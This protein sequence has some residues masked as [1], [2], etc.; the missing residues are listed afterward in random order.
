M[1]VRFPRKYVVPPPAPLHTRY[2]TLCSASYG[3]QSARFSNHSMT[4]FDWDLFLHYRANECTATERERFER[5]LAADPDRRR[6]ADATIIAAERMARPH[7]PLRLPRSR[8]VTARWPTLVAAGVIGVVV[9]LG[10]WQLTLRDHAHAASTLAREH[11][12]ATRAGERADAQLPDGS[13]VI[14]GPA[15]T[16]RYAAALLT[17][18]AQSRDVALTGEAFFEVVH[19]TAHPFRVHTRGT[20]TEDVGT[21]FDLRAYETDSAVRIVVASGAVSVRAIAHP[22]PLVLPR[23]TIGVVDPAG[24]VR[25][26]SH[27][28]IDRYLAW[29]KGQLVFTN[30]PLPVA[31]L[32]LGRWFDLDIRLGAP[33]L[34]PRSLTATFADDPVPDVLHALEES[35]DVK[36]IV[37]GHTVRLDP[38]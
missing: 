1:P 21:A 28:A 4:D 27:V 29:T 19:D 22:S 38:R 33:Q 31:V 36:A 23:G 15:S 30:T 3:W 17:G 12:I 18:G 35:L 20:T 2:H 7:R 5:W 9:G 32:E 8:S 24:D 14:L 26:T 6:M 11:V 16:L 13:H 25:I 34:A 37:D 10:S